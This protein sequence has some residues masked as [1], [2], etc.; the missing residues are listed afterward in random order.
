[1][2]QDLEPFYVPTHTPLINSCSYC[3]PSVNHEPTAFY[4]YPCG[5]THLA[6]KNCFL[7]HF[8][9]YRDPCILCVKEGFLITTEPDQAKITVTICVAIGILVLFLTLF[10][11]LNI[12]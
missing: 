1:M 6:H 3:A 5:R 11:V 9:I 7:Q 4:M 12:I 2:D 10:F 8:R